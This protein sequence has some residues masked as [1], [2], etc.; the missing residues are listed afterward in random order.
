MSTKWEDIANEEQ[1]GEYKQKTGFPVIPEG[2]RVLQT[3]EEIKMDSYKG[4]DHENLNLKW[5][6]DSPKDYIGRVYYQTIYING[7]DPTGPYYDPAKQD[8]DIADA[9]RMVLAID[10]HAGREIAALG[11]EPEEVDFQKHLT[12]AQ[13]MAVLGV[14]KTGKQVVRGISGVDKDAIKEATKPAKQA[15]P[16]DKPVDN[17][18]SVEDDDIPF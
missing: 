1:T 17:G 12:G 8:K 18:F 15:K 7:S 11:R 16:V 10:Y 6:I 14:S 9:R 2:T 3:L 5:K 13:M 4:S